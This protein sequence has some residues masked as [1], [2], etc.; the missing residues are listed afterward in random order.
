MTLCILDKAIKL[1][2]LAGVIA[3]IV[4]ISVIA[5]ILTVAVIIMIKYYDRFK[6]TKFFIRM[7]HLILH[8]GMIITIAGI[9]I[10]Q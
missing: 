6:Q 10:M 5:I 7:S 4:I 1:C 2:S 8:K 9:I 3:V